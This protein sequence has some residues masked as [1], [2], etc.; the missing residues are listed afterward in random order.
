MCKLANAAS[1]R[2]IRLW[3]IHGLVESATGKNQVFPGARVK[4]PMSR[5]TLAQSSATLETR[6]TTE[7]FV[8]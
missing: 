8:S 5:E 2:S 4:K 1:E 7:E 6:L 3:V